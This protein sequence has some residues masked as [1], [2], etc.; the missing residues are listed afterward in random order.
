VAVAGP[1]AAHVTVHPAS[2]P[3]G[4]QDAE[5]TFRVPNER[6]DANTVR[7]QVFFP[8]SPPFLTVD[9][10][11]VPGWTATVH[12][13]NLPRPIPSDDGPVTQVVSDITWM[14]T[15]GGI[16]RGQYEDF[17][18]SVGSLPSRPGAVDFKALQTYSSGEVVRWIEVPT[19]QV[20]EPDTPAPVLTLTGP[21]PRAPAGAAAG[22]GSGSGSSDALALSALVLSVLALAGAGVVVARGR[23]PTGG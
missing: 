4:A 20:P 3:A 18:V 16:T 9:V 23:R 1:A 2:V 10:L 12:V 19:P 5:I 17:A 14:A 15:A 7:L 6:D 8:T 21:S 13:V 11:P 22:G